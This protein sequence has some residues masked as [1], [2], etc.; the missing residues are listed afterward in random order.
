ML[1]RADAAL[2]DDDTAVDIA[3]VYVKGTSAAECQARL[4][5]VLAE[6]VRTTTDDD[7]AGA[8]EVSSTPA[9]DAV[10]ADEVE[11]TVSSGV[12]VDD[13]ADSSSDSGHEP[14]PVD[15][16]AQSS[17]SESSPGEESA[18]GE[19][20]AVADAERPTTAEGPPQ[21]DPPPVRGMLA[22]QRRSLTI[23]SST[24]D[25]RGLRTPVAV[26]APQPPPGSRLAVDGA[27]PT[28]SRSTV[29]T[30]GLGQA[31]PLRVGNKP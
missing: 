20:A 15:G 9:P 6:I 21:K 28:A 3:D 26:P 11:D 25:G 13:D 19:P 5:D 7:V 4:Q 1:A 29:N 10:V 14:S 12:S 17:S 31:T 27:P 23:A 24:T 16:V 8:R 22:S 2:G 30:L 18:P